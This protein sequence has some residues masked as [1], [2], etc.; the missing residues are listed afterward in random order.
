M[1][2]RCDRGFLPPWIRSA[3]VTV[4][5]FHW[6]ES[7]SVFVPLEQPQTS[8]PVYV[9]WPNLFK[10][11]RLYNHKSACMFFFFTKPLL[12][13]RIRPLY[14]NTTCFSSPALVCREPS[15]GNVINLIIFTCLA[16]EGCAFFSSHRQ[17][18]EDPCNVKWCIWAQL[19]F[20]R[21]LRRF[22]CRGR[23]L[24]VTG[25]YNHTRIFRYVTACEA[26]TVQICRRARGTTKM[27]NDNNRPPACLH[28]GLSDE[29]Q[30][31][32]L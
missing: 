23:F 21:V 19:F 11:E 15:H 8:L 32:S 24:S 4:D 17:R 27:N 16:F 31:I 20:V 13:Q 10:I 1:D 5:L 25:N 14:N 2:T 6:K 12:V 18:L 7:A 30:V 29:K 9:F 28:Q 26:W 22:C 3:G